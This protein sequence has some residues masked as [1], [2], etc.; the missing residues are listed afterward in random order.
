MPPRSPPCSATRA[1]RAAPGGVAARCVSDGL[2]HCKDGAAVLLATCWGGCDRLDVLAELRRRGLLDGRADYAPH[3]VSAPRRD[4]DASRTA[5][6]LRIWR[7]TQRGAGTIVRRYLAS[8]G[9]A[10]E[11]WPRAALPPTLP[12]AQR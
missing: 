8:R 5:R 10:L 12:A 6:A 7:D 11:H 2:S 1:A 4:D 9:I 3:I